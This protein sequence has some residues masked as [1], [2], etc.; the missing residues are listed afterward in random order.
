MMQQISSL[1]DASL[2]KQILA[3]IV[4]AYELIT[5]DELVT[6]V[7]QLENVANDPTLIREIISLCGS[8]LTLRNDTVYFVH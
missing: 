4:I 3:L 8:F 1:D 7:E 5:L 2:C 6:L